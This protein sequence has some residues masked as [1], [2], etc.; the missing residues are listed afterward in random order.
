MPK[1]TTTSVNSVPLFRV[2]ENGVS[3]RLRYT[4]TKTRVFSVS[5]A[6]SFISSVNN[7][8]YTYYIAK[9]GSVDTSSGVQT[10][11]G[12]GT[13]TQAVAIRHLVSLATN[14]Y[15]ELWVECD[16]AATGN[17]TVQLCNFIIQ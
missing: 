17:P 3:N 6:L 1:I 2:D 13:D 10:K 9:G 16:D 4:G 14:E 5:A 15:V 8:T 7:K 11:I 12:T